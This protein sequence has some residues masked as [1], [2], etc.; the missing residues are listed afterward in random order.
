MSDLKLLSSLRKMPNGVSS[1]DYLLKENRQNLK[2]IE[3]AF[4]RT[5]KNN[6]DLTDSISSL[7]SSLSTLSGTVSTRNYVVSASSGG[8]TTT[9]TSYSDVTN[10]SC[11]ITTTGNP[12]MVFIQPTADDSLAGSY[13]RFS[14]AA[15]NYGMITVL[16]DSTILFY[17]SIDVSSSDN[18]IPPMLFKFD[19]PSAG[20]YTYKAQ[21]KVVIS[22][23][24]YVVN[25][26]LVVL[27]W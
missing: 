17:G 1:E 15:V 9:S 8:Y 21:A 3:D 10:L 12:V 14:G 27:E 7:T 5:H 4:R 11:T 22:G 6:S 19:V 20:T 24:C 2:A 23:T 26:Q 13:F 16:R 18:Q 25:C